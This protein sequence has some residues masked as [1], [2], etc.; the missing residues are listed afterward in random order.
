[1]RSEAF[2]LQ[3]AGVEQ[4]LINPPVEEVITEGEHTHIVRDVQ[5]AST[6]EVQD[7][8]ERAGMS[9]GNNFICVGK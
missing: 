4:S 1:M 5:L 9:N 2:N 3:A 6:V 7:G 8:V